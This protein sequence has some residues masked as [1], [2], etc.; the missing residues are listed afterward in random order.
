MKSSLVDM[1][2]VELLLAT[3]EEDMVS[4]EFMKL[5]GLA[6]NTTPSKEM[7]E[8]ICSVFVKTSPRNR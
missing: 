3:V 2:D 7:K 8:A 4:P 5:N 6:I 1:I